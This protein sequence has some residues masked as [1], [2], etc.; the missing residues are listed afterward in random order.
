LAA[1]QTPR[2]ARPSR[3]QKNKAYAAATDA[4]RKDAS[5]AEISNLATT[6]LLLRPLSALNAKSYQAQIATAGIWP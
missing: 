5:Y 2:C 1:R 3:R 6:Q 4:L